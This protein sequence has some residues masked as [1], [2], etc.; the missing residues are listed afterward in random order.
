MTKIKQHT[1]KEMKE[2]VINKLA[3]RGVRL[4]DIA[5]IVYTLQQ[6]YSPE[7][8]IE[9]CLGH[10]DGVLNKREIL[11]TLLTGLALDELAEQKGLPQP[12]QHLVE[13]DEGLF[14]IDEILALSI[15]NV[16]GS[17][18]LTSFGYLDKH[19]IGI[20]KELDSQIGGKTNTFL[21]DL[22]GA[23]AA[24]ASSKLAHSQR[25]KEERINA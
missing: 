6:Q 17:I 24:A 1:A 19:K 5:V 11:H 14:G 16:Y 10:V 8:T 20:I 12:L 18:A 15:V 21:D 4:T 9:E 2:Y 22:V 7:I 25:D 23:I 13:T 3:E